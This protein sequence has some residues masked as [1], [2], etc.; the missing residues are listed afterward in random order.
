MMTEV[1]LL[2]AKFVV[3]VL[4][5]VTLWGVS[6]AVFAYGFLGHKI[7][8]N[9][10][11]AH[12]SP[13]TRAMIDKILADQ[14][15]ADASVWPD[16]MKNNGRCAVNLTKA[17]LSERE[18]TKRAFSSQKAQAWNTQ[19][20]AQSGCADELNADVKQLTK[21]ILMAATLKSAQTMQQHYVDNH[22]DYQFWNTSKSWHYVNIPPQQTYEQIP[23]APNGDIISAI[24]TFTAILTN[25]GPR[26]GVIMQALNDYLADLPAEQKIAT[27]RLFSLRFLVHLIADLHQPLHSGYKAD[28]G[29]NRIAVKWFD[30]KTNLHQVWDTKLIEGQHRSQAQFEQMIGQTTLADKQLYAKSQLMDWL[31][32]ALVLRVG[33][34]DIG[35][36]NLQFGNDYLTVQQ[37]KYNRQLQKAAVR[38]AA[39]LDNI[40]RAN[41]PL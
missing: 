39:T 29:G 30:Q 22:K 38:L 6:P 41:K 36:Y 40:F 14:S 32:E 27:M 11:Y 7:I 2:V 12:L 34:Y 10:A 25:Q 26:H 15:I 13:E 28:L 21:R 16:V 4:L 31:Q 8:A 1:R 23:K 9:G 24:E 17:A 35:K 5:G 20:V 18:S 33:V 19:Q 37:D 3:A